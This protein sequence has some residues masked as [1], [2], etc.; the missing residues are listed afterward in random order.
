MAQTLE[1][2][3]GRDLTGVDL[4]DLLQIGRFCDILQAAEAGI[5][6]EWPIRDAL[7]VV[8]LVLVQGGR[9]LGWI[10]AE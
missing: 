6:V 2:D 1:G 4:A 10:V 3:V 9:H 5:G 8:L 7:E